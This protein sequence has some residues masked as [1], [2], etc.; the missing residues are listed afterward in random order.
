MGSDGAR[1]A[2]MRPLTSG[3]PLLSAD[4]EILTVGSR[5]QTQHTVVSG[6]DGSWYAGTIVELHAAD[7]TA[8]VIYDDGEECADWTRTAV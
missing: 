6:G 1:A 8:T 2:E 3:Q 4:G 7:E 5:V